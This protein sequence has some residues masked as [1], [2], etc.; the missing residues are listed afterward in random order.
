M[1]SNSKSPA[2]ADT[3]N[4]A[5][6]VGDH[7]E[8]PVSFKN[9]VTRSQNQERRVFGRNDLT[10]HGD[11]LHVGHSRTPAARIVPDVVH[12]GMWRVKLPTGITD[13]VNRTRARDAACTHVL[14]VVNLRHQETALGASPMRKNE[15]A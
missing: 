15:G 12:G 7:L 6:N 2:P 13:M 14:A 9:S 8:G 10:W 1:H 5:E 3:G 4:G 11:A